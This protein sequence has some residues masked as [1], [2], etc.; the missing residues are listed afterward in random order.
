MYSI[1]NTR[2]FIYATVASASI[3]L[4]LVVYMLILK[5]AF[6]KLQQMKFSLS[7]R[8]FKMQHALARSL[9]YQVRSSVCVKHRFSSL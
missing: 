7:E 2:L 5:A 8:T 3:A 6:T 4:W 9:V 1:D